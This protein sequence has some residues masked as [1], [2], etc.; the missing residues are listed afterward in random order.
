MNGLD[1]MTEI[2]M[3][4]LINVLHPQQPRSESKH[5][6]TELLNINWPMGGSMDWEAVLFGNVWEYI[7]S[8]WVSRV[9]GEMP[10][11]HLYVYKPGEVEMN[12]VVGSVAGISKVDGVDTVLVEH[13]LRYSTEQT[14][15][16]ENLRYYHQVR[17]YCYMTGCR[18]VWMP[19]LYLGCRPPDVKAV[20]YQFQVSDQECAET[21]NMMMNLKEYLEFQQAKE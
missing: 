20:M 4:D 8:R 17:S 19:V 3:E 9:V 7:S 6:V 14:D 15:P 12:D 11:S 5:H 10:S 16:R 1:R 21:W 2:P 13:K 18:E